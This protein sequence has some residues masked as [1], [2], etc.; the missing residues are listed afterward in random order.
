MKF[1]T[2]FKEA[3]ATVFSNAFEQWVVGLLI[4]VQTHHLNMLDS[5]NKI[6]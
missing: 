5:L 6:T 2:S 1:D 3:N 4:T